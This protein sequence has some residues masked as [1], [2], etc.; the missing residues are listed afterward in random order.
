MEAVGVV[1]SVLLGIVYANFLEWA[2]H[3]YILHGLGKKKSSPL[4]FHFHKH[5]KVTRKFDGSDPDY[6]KGFFGE[7]RE[8]AA[9][10]LLVLLHVPLIYVFPAFF[11]TLLAYTCTYYLMHRKFHL[12]P[13]WGKKW[14]PWHWDHH[15]KYQ[16]HNWCVVQ[17]MFDH[18]MHT[19]KKSKKV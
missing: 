4:S 12:D 15:M 9:L 18:F 10:S 16:N 5:H 8:V 19:R 2:T 6:M 14:M 1:F 17:P 11:F 13:E 7:G 3:K